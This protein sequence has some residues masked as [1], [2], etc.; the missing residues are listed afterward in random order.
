MPRLE[1]HPRITV[2]DDQ[3]LMRKL[4][5][6]AIES[7]GFGPESIRLIS[8]ADEAQKHIHDPTAPP[9]N[10][11]IL[12]LGLGDYQSGITVLKLLKGDKSPWKDVPVIVVTVDSRPEVEKTCLGLGAKAVIRKPFD[13]AVLQKH[14]QEALLG[15]M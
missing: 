14:M 11:V 1:R 15:N 2:I 10:L 9:P 7:F 4:Y 3:P 8:T 12:D 13:I 6:R 5:A